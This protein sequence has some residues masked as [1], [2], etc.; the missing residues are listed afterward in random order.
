MMGT[1]LRRIDGA[2]G[3]SDNFANEMNN[4]VHSTAIYSVT[5]RQTGRKWR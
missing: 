5:L 4:C 2:S 3:I 1:S